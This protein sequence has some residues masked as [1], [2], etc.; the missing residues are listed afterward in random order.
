MSDTETENPDTFLPAGHPDHGWEYRLER[1]VV[2][3]IDE[4]VASGALPAAMADALR[5]VVAVHSSYVNVAGRSYGR[6]YTCEPVHGVP[7]ATLR[8]LAAAWG[9]HPDHPYAS[10]TY[11]HHVVSFADLY[12]AGTWERLYDARRAEPAQA[13]PRT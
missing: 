4:D 1:F 9:D 10:A 12:A 11:S 2:A 7:C 5:C 13:A 8:S 6:C 3:R